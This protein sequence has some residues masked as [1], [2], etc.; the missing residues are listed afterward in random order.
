MCA[1]RSGASD[2]ADSLPSHCARLSSRL[3]G[4]V[5]SDHLERVKGQGHQPD[6]VRHFKKSWNEK[7]GRIKIAKWSED[8]CEILDSVNVTSGEQAEIQRLV[9]DENADWL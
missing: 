9:F 6:K 1:E 8:R 4:R 2:C 7:L 3:S 5:R